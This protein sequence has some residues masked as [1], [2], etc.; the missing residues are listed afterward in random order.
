MNSRQREIML[1]AQEECAEVIQAIS[2]CFRFGLTDVYEGKTNLQRL[3][4]EL[5]DLKCMI[6]LMEESGVTYGTNVFDAE[7]NKR[8][9]LKKWSNVF[10][11]EK[12]SENA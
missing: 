5:G 12:V 7:L 1:I 6:S 9:R 2:K 3:E 11:E 10:K 4:E 8:V